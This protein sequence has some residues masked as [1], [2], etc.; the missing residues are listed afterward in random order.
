MFSS[1]RSTSPTPSYDSTD[2]VKGLK[3]KEL[4]TQDDEQDAALPGLASNSGS[5]VY[6]CIPQSHGHDSGNKWAFST[7]NARYALPSSGQTFYKTETAREHWAPKFTLIQKIKPGGSVDEFETLATIHHKVIGSSVFEFAN[8]DKIPSNV[9]MRKEKSNAPRA[10]GF[11]GRDRIVT[12]PDGREARWRMGSR[13]C[14]LVLNNES[15]TPLARFHRSRDLIFTKHKKP[16]H[17]LE[18]FPAA[19]SPNG[20]TS[21]GYENGILNETERK[22][23][24]F[25]LVTWLYVEKVRKDR[26]AYDGEGGGGA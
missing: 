10:Y 26:D 14:T 22:M 8:G 24:E 18:F 19:L 5:L 25:I 21:S 13:E 4:Y 17:M 23:V 15:R 3:G 16:P 20:S 9:L 1:K 12:L 6:D 11:F 2:E 7:L